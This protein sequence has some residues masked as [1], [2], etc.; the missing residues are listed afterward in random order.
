[1]NSVKTE[2]HGASTL[3][4]LTAH[5]G[6]PQLSTREYISELGKE[7]APPVPGAEGT[8][9]VRSETLAMLRFPTFHMTPPSSD[10]VKR[11]LWKAPAAAISYVIEPNEHFPPNTWLYVCQDQ[12]YNI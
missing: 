9:W 6:G 4:V 8:F 10:E 11:V 7:G 1:M 5:Q 12:S 3:N 2:S